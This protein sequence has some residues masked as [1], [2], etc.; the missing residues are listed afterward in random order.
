MTE[1]N[2]NDFRKEELN[3]TIDKLS[4]LDLYCPIDRKGIEEG[5]KRVN[6]I[7][8]SN[9]EKETAKMEL[10][11]IVMRNS[12]MVKW[13]KDEWDDY[14]YDGKFFIIMKNGAWIGFYNL[15]FVISIIIK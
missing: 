3:K 4:A 9:F 14:K 10:I 7:N 8:L 12:D 5:L 15:D 13:D 1:I 6:A 2:L 11:K